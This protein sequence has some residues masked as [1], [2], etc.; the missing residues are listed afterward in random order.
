[1]PA[2]CFCVLVCQYENYT[3][4]EHDGSILP[5]PQAYIPERVLYGNYLGIG[6]FNAPTD[7][8]A[9]ENYIIYLLY[10]GNGRIVV[11]N[12]DFT[13]PCAFWKHGA[14]RSAVCLLLSCFK[15]EKNMNIFMRFPQGKKKALTLSYDD[16]VE[17]DARLIG[18]MDRYGIKG[19]FNINSGLFA[20][21]GTVYPS[22]QIHR[23]MT[24]KSARALYGGSGHEVAVH[25]LTHPMLEQLSSPVMLEE[26]MRDRSNLEQMFGTIVRGMAY[27]YGTYSDSVVEGLKQA[28]IVYS[29][30]VKFTE[31]FRIPT[32]WLRLEATCHHNNPNLM[33]LAQ[34]FIN[35][36]PDRA[37]WLFYLWG[38]SYE[39]EAN[40]NWD[41]IERFCELAGGRT[42]I[43]YAT[44]IAVYD[45]ITAY[46]RLQ[47]SLDAS[48]VC[49]PSAL[50]LWLEKGGKIY[51]VKAGR[52]T[53]L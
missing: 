52:Q 41:V 40:Q 11:L 10:A 18:I 19:T 8:H 36:E 1:M 29:R 38:H 53:M 44:N 43:W 24:A 26:V 47:F 46:R 37:P 31:D 39:F 7:I 51:E 3:Y 30:T 21:E 15:E 28:G 45:Y 12:P 25:T 5:A 32:D 13:L 49:N 22:G 27:P 16:G 9:D 35:E 4:S 33:K 2:A 23:R 34:R 42:D 48:L 50:D 17:Q 14:V 20:P 6:S